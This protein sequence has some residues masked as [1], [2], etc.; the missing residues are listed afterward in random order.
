MK[1]TQGVS[2]PLRCFVSRYFFQNFFFFCDESKSLPMI[3]FALVICL[4]NFCIIFTPLHI[5]SFFSDKFNKILI[6]VVFLAIII[7]SHSN[8]IFDSACKSCLLK[9]QNN[10]NAY[11]LWFFFL[12]SNNTKVNFFNRYVELVFLFIKC[13]LCP[14]ATLMSQN[15]TNILIRFFKLDVCL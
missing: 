15:K 7:N 10:A 14:S 1:L 9:K 8:L 13:K 3:F 11:F 12:I 4:H 2:L 6:L 5:M